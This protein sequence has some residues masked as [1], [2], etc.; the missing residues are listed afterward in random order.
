M[1]YQPFVITKKARA[2]HVG[3]YI[4]PLNKEAKKSAFWGRIASVGQETICDRIIVHL[5]YADGMMIAFTP[6]EDVL[7]I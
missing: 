4:T 2:L 6:D 5:E 3:D 1:E 7:V